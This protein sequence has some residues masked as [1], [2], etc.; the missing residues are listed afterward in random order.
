MRMMTMCVNLNKENEKT[1]M[2]Q[3]HDAYKNSRP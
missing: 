2:T 1:K 3:K